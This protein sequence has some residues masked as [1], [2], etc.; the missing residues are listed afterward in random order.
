MIAA[1]FVDPKGVYAALDDVEVWPEARDARLYAGPYAVVAHPPCARWGRYWYGGPR[2]PDRK[3]L[4]DDGG[5]FASALASAR[6]WGGV[7]E[8]PAYSKAW[9][10]FGLAKPPRAGGWVRADDRGGWTCQVEQG[11][12]G[13]R[14]RKATW[15]Y[16]RGVELPPL[17]WGPSALP[18]QAIAG[19]TLAERRLAIRPPPGMS[20]AERAMRRAWLHAY[21]QATGKAY[22]TPELMSKRQRAATPP[23]FRDLLLGMARSVYARAETG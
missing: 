11:S 15:L 22:C 5:C 6:R 8:H 4:G 20:E 21:E 12:Y 9:D 10:A 13:H 23:A 16:A 7:L 3:V 18:A 14:C 17:R 1:L 19:F 2:T